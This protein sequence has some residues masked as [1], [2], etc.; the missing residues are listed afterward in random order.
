MKGLGL[1]ACVLAALTF[2]QVWVWQ[3]DDTLWW[4]AAQV[5][6]SA[7][8][9][10]VNLAVLA[11]RQGDEDGAEALLDRATVLSSFQGDFDRAW[12]LD[13]VSAT[14]ATLRISQGRLTEARTLLEGA[15]PLSARAAVCQRMPAVC[16]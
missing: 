15:P 11:I 1:L 5:T 3:S 14:R 7:P 4:H 16:G 8:R 9:P 6:P 12:T 13:L 2:R 10:W